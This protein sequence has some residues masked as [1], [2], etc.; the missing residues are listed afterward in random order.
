MADAAERRDG[1][2]V[3]R[4]LRSRAD[5][6]APQADGATALHWAAHWGDAETATR[7]IAAGANAD[8]VNDL[9]VSPLHLACATGNVAVVTLL[10]KNGARTEVRPQGGE[11]PLMVAARTGRLDIVRAL[12]EATAD[13][14]GADS[15]RGQTALMWAA[16]EH[17]A[18]VVRVLV[19][20]GADP[21]Q[22]SRGGFTAL[23]FAGRVGDP[24]VT[25][26]LL[27]AGARLED[28]AAT[29]GTALLLAAEGEA[30]IVAKDFKRTA[31]AS[32]H[33]E[34]A[35]LLVERGANPNATDEFGH[36]A[37]H[38]AVRKA[39]HRLIKALIAHHADL[40][41]RMTRDELPLPGDFNARD[42]LAG[43][44]PFFLAAAAS[45]LEAMRLLADA[46]ADPRMAGVLGVTP[47]MAA[48]GAHQYESRLPP[49]SRQIEAIT[50]CLSLGNDI[51]AGDNGG[52]TAVHYAVQ[53]GVDEV[54]TF[55]VEHGAKPD[56]R[57]RRGRTPLD[58]A[59]SNPSR[60]R[61]QSAALLRRY[62][63][64]PPATVR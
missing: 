9:G 7:L 54:L 6:N 20:H 35:I 41:A 21:N 17:H 2:A 52:Q 24:V 33:E 31:Y 43:A 49:Q 18:E 45:D 34:T 61:P 39:K 29:G 59:V 42:G 46:G 19:A 4:L 57:D 40:D 32:G 11:T 16:N 62:L 50:L 26:V 12:L 13:V 23:M 60:P 44:T 30:A 48:V 27:D 56:A 3:Q 1:A 63:D 15:V 22:R 51:N 53:M 58:V 47:L 38:L 10:L 14:N 55:L 28:T 64:A 8:V 25:Q 5:V 37:L 36:T